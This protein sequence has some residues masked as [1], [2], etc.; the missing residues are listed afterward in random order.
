MLIDILSTTSYAQYNVKLA[1]I[2]GLEAA[3]YINQLININEKAV[4]KSKMKEGYIKLKRSYITERTTFVKSKQLQIENNLIDAGLISRDSSDPDLVKVDTEALTSL[5]MSEDESLI[6]DISKISKKKGGTKIAREQEV[7]VN[8]KECITT[9]NE[10]LRKA[11]YDW[12]DAA[13]FKHGSLTPKAVTIAQG[14][15]DAFSNHNLDLAL[16]L[17]EFAAVGGY[18]YMTNAIKN[19]AK[20]RS[21]T[22]TYIAPAQLH[23]QRDRNV[24]LGDDI[25]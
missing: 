18:A 7:E 4:R 1:H 21:T 3:I 2:L 20:N 17:L 23:T 9:E 15:V 14:Q 13:L 16:D 10:E 12:I 11:Y 6:K 5:V 22:N 8:L 24:I 19:Y 25:F